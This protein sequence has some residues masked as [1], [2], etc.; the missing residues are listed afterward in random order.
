MSFPMKKSLLLLLLVLTSFAYSYEKISSLNEMKQVFAN[1]DE[2][3][4]V[5]FDV[6][7]V[8][9][10]TEDHFMHP[11]ALSSFGYALQKIRKSYSEKDFEEKMSLTVLLPR[12]VLIEEHSPLLLR[13]LQ[14]RGV[15]V[16]GLTSCPTGP[17]GK[18]AKIEDWRVDHLL[19]LGID[20]SPAFSAFDRFTLPLG[21]SPAIFQKGILFSYGYKKGDV[22]KAFLEKTAFRPSKVILFDDLVENLESEEKALS[23]MGITHQAYLYEGAAKFFKELDT[24]VIERQLEHVFTHETWLKDEECK[25]L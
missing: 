25:S 16:M 20:F 11:Y 19:S 13:T 21:K 4:L 1:L 12:R 23:E 15:K 5:I 2:E 14:N 10:T 22:L 3:A 6:D 18:I 7:E 24:D 8:L 9:I 17:L